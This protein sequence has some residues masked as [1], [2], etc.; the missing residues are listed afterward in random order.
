MP[1]HLEKGKKVHDQDARGAGTLT[2]SSES[3]CSKLPDHQSCGCLFTS[4]SRHESLV[5]CLDHI[6]FRILRLIPRLRSDLWKLTAALLLSDPELL[7]KPFNFV[8]G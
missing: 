8:F 6:L 3:P 4:A 1:A 7:N 2:K 5:N